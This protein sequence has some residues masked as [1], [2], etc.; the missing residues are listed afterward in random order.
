MFTTQ[1]THMEV[2]RQP[3]GLHSLLLPSESQESNSGHR[4]WWKA[5]LLTEQ[6]QWPIN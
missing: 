1:Y 3:A 4:D 6:S 5:L 2:G